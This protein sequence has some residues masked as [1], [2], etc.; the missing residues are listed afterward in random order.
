MWSVAREMT[1]NLRPRS[2]KDEE[3]GL[4]EQDCVNKRKEELAPV[5][6]RLD[7]ATLHINH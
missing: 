5:A 2:V 6:Q 4:W 3:K 7:N 1:S